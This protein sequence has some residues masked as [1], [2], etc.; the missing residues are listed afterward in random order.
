MP[1]HH[2]D[3]HRY[4]EA[5]AASC[6]RSTRPRWY[7]A[8]TR[9]NCEQAVREALAANGFEAYLPERERWRHGPNMNMRY[10]IREPMFPGY[11]LVRRCMDRWSY[12]GICRTRG[13]AQLQGTSWD[14][15]EVVPD[16]EVAAIRALQRSRLP[17]WP[18][19]YP[20]EGQAVRVNEGPLA[21]ME[22]TLVKL[23]SM[24]AVLVLSIAALRK[25]VAVE[26]S[27]SQVVPLQDTRPCLARGV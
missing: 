14:S 11:V 1:L 27:R 23:N 3:Q 16:N 19:P 15:L 26:I 12:L 7:V 21:D 17:N 6:A 22:G 24:Q 5:M 9:R 20:G 13:V 8:S 18:Y 4:S 10:L 2:V 25:S